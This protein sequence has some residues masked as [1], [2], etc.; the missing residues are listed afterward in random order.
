[1]FPLHAPCP[2]DLPSQSFQDLTAQSFP[3]TGGV[4]GGVRFVVALDTKKELFRSAR[5]FYRKINAESGASHTFFHRKPFFFQELGN[6]FLKSVTSIPFPGRLGDE[7]FLLCVIEEILS[8]T[9][10]VFLSAHLPDA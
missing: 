3:V 6:G 4:L 7:A 8:G 1:M 9:Y 5:I 10:C 2:P